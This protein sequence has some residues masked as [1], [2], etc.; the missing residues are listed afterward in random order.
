MKRIVILK[1]MNFSNCPNKCPSCGSYT[2]VN[3]E[4]GCYCNTCDWER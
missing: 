4:M 2:V 1:F 3:G